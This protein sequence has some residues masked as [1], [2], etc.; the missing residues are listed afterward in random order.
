MNWIAIFI[1]FGIL[2]AFNI[3]AYLSKKATI[4]VPVV[5]A[6]SDEEIEQRLMAQRKSKELQKAKEGMEYKDFMSC[7]KCQTCNEQCHLHYI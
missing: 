4:N 6:L 3:L 1:F 7:K 2:L 5:Y